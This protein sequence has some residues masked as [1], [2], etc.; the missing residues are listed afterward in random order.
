MYTKEEMLLKFLEDGP[1][2]V[3]FLKTHP[4]V[5][6]PVKLN[7]DVITF[8]YDYNAEDPIRDFVIDEKGVRATLRFGGAYHNTFVPWDALAV[9]RND[10]VV[11][12]YFLKEIVYTNDEEPAPSKPS[13]KLVQ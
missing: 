13:L 8:F 1:T 11:V 5:E 6:L 7:G 9:I 3:H 10:Q 2:H 4:D 12:Q